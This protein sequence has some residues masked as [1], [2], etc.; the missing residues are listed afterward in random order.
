M[1][2]ATGDG[3]A[4]IVVK[5]GDDDGSEYGWLSVAGDRGGSQHRLVAEMATSVITGGAPVCRWQAAVAAAEY[6]Q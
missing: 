4:G 2:V 1:I 3:G 5:G 6:W